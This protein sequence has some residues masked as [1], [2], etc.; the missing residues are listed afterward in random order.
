[1]PLQRALQVDDGHRLR[2]DLVHAERQAA[3]VFVA[4]AGAVR[5]RIGVAAAAPARR[6][7]AVVALNPSIS[8][9]WRSIKTTA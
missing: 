1:M 6:R 5:A 8:G 4:D 2:E 7:I 9:I 3:R